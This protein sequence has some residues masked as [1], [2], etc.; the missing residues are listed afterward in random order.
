MLPNPQRMA[1]TRALLNFRFTRTEFTDERDQLLYAYSL[2]KDL[3][4][5][6]ITIDMIIEQTNPI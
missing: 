4:R 1:T 2:V 5:K 3:K 6:N